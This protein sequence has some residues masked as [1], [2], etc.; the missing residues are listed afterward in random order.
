MK[1]NNKGFSLVELLAVI[2]ILGLLATIGIVATTSLVDKA[3][4]DKMDSQKNTVTM[5]AQTYMQN[6]KNLGPKIIGE[7]KVIRVSDLRK[8]NYLTEDIKNEKGESC[9]EK[10]YVRVYKLSNTEYTYTT[11]LY[12][13][14]E[15]IPA[16]QDVPTPKVEA[17]FSDSTGE[18]KDKNLNNV[19]DAYLYIELNAA[20]EEEIQEYKDN[21]TEILM[22]G[23]SF[24]IFVKKMVKN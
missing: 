11:F 7:T 16:K 6:N 19:S 18:I 17:K 12:C 13:G 2:V 14:N 22:D 10:S 4:K 8:M 3:K 1:K 5:S 23:Y 9:M 24:S 15:E 20:S 21:G